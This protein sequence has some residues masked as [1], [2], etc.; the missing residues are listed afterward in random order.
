M[1]SDAQ[2][3]VLT[4][5]AQGV[6]LRQIAKLAGLS[7]RTAQRIQGG[8]AIRPSTLAAVLAIT[9]AL[10][11]GQKVNAYASKRLLRALVKEGYSQAELARRMGLRSGRIR[12]D[13]QRI[14]VRNAL[15]VRALYRQITEA[16]T[17]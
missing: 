14:T 1:A 7:Y 5:Q 17:V 9:P 12:W 2:R 11:H 3:Y 8:A 13:D 15:R 4:L 6:G 10:A 16:Q